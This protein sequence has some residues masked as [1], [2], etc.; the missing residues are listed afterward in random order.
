MNEE[1]QKGDIIF[2]VYCDKFLMLEVQDVIRTLDNAYCIV[3]TID[4]VTSTR[5]S[6]VLPTDLKKY[7]FFRTSL[8]SFFTVHENIAV[9]LFKDFIDSSENV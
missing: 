7:E 9:Q 2:Y 4:I 5:F 3:R 1:I 8:G 6:N